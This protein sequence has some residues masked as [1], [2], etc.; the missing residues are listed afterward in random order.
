MKHIERYHEFNNEEQVN[1]GL[2]KN[3]LF[4]PFALLFFPFALSVTQLS[5]PRIA[6]S[7]LTGQI[8][9][10]YNL[11]RLI[12]AMEKLLSSK[13]YDIS[14]IERKKIKKYLDQLHKKR[15]KYPTLE[16]YK[17]GLIKYR[18]MVNFR[19]VDYLKKSILE[20]EPQMLTIEEMAK[21]L[22]KGYKNIKQHD[23]KKLTYSDH[24][25]YDEEE[26]YGF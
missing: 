18:H 2:I 6:K 19:N 9:L 26:E 11:P 14:D 22:K 17:E 12:Q 15:A 4:F 7:V 25:H 23:V 16:K 20:H 3:I 24:E 10:F 21:E 1:E 5:H 8:D 13:D